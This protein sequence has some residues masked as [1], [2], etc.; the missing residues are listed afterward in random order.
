MIGNMGLG[1][2]MSGNENIAI[3]DHAYSNGGGTRTIG[4]G[5]ESVWLGGTDVIGIGKYTM[6]RGNSQTGGIGIGYY[7]GR[8]N[9]GDH[10]VY[11]GYEIWI[12]NRFKSIFYRRI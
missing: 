10:N 3:G 11:I 5:G 4:L 9:A 8:N 12:W 1:R 6:S 7:A 2:S